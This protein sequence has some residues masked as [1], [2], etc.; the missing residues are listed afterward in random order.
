MHYGIGI[1]SRSCELEMLLTNALVITKTK[2]SQ[3]LGAVPLDPRIWDL[4]LGIGTPPE[5][6]LPTPLLDYHSSATNR[7]TM[8]MA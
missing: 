4:L 6:F 8:M 5:K 1:T 3:W 2:P 7:T